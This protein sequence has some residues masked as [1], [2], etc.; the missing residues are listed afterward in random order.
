VLM[1]IRWH[2]RT[3]AGLVMLTALFA[4]VYSLAEGA[5]VGV[6]AFT[7]VYLISVTISAVG[8][9]RARRNAR[10]RSSRPGTT[11]IQ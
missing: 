7:S 6:I 1:T 10:S 8:Y 5:P 2:R 3:A 9:W 11:P 4:F